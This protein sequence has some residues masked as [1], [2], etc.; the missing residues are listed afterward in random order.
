MR[1]V[2]Y[3]LLSL[4][5]LPCLVLF[6]GCGENED[7]PVL[8][9]ITESMIMLDYSST[10]YNGQEK[11][12]AV[13]VSLN[14]SE[15]DA[16]HY[17]VTYKNNVNVGTAKVTVS[18]NENSTLLKGSATRSFSITRVNK[19]VSN[20]AELVEAL[21]DSNYTT[22]Y[23]N[24]NINIPANETLT[25]DQGKTLNIGVFNLDNNGTLIN[26]G[27]LV[28][29]YKQTGVGTIT[30]NGLITANV[31]TRTELVD[32]IGY[33][34]KIVLAD[35]IK[36]GVNPL[37]SVEISATT[38]P[39]QITIDLNGKNLETNIIVNGS[40]THKVTVS[41]KNSS[42]ANTPTIGTINHSYGLIVAG[43]GKA[44][45]NADL[46]VNL[47]NLNFVGLLG[48]I[49]TDQQYSDGKIEVTKCTFEGKNYT[50]TVQNKLCVG[51]NLGASYGYKFSNCTFIGYTA[52][53]A[54]HGT[55]SLTGNTF[56]AKGEAYVNPNTFTDECKATGSAIII[57]SSTNSSAALKV[58]FAN[59]GN[60]T[61][62]SDCGYGI[63]EFILNPNDE[64]L[65]VYSE[66]TLAGAMKIIT[67]KEHYVFENE[68]IEGLLK[69]DRS[70]KV[71]QD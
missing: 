1:K 9:Q 8:T 61:I 49:Y 21:Q 22:I 66:T 50:E 59:V 26:N 71:N 2:S 48:G 63:E 24:G 32:A 31:K 27:N 14:G 25:I 15:V 23:C 55:H 46:Y 62:K 54:K 18:A 70:F 47:N 10:M 44:A 13:T 28:L 6:S 11:K 65:N 7:P 58:F 30:N 37:D 52:Y 38:R 16:A 68:D 41:I 35:A 20:Y 53:I 67:E 60:T 4:L 43:N 51:A 45:N 69:T 19:T 64:N 39:V 56:E 42:T 29:N 40:Q 12:P 34:D 17:N 5:I 3:L 33:A 57:N 36:G